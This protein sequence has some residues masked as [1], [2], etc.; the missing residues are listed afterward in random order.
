M[1]KKK[2][3]TITRSEF[4]PWIRAVLKKLIVAELFKKFT[5]FMESKDLLPCS[6][7]PATGSFPEPD[8]SSPQTTNPLL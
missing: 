6:Q 4:T 1:L 7:E 5:A 3:P 8:E 2:Q